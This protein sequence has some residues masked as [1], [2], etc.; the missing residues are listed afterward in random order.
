MFVL[1]G[2]ALLAALAAPAVALLSTSDINS[3]IR[4]AYSG[5]TGMVVSW[6]TFQHLSNPS[7]KYGLTAN[8][9]TMTASSSVSVTYPSSLTYN[10]HVK[11]TGLQPNTVYYFMPS[12][13]N[14]NETSPGPYTFKTSM[15]AGDMTP[16]TFAFVADLGTMGPEGLSTT[17][18]KGVDPHGILKPGEINTIQALSQHMNDFDF[19]FHGGD[20]A[21]AGMPCVVTLL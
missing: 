14:A 2:A 1:Y 19:L 6:N 20:I 9:L 5:S 21:Y 13:L 3:Q 11:I 16:Y 18:G 12:D 10:N 15:P 4:S 7:V 17:S 8:S